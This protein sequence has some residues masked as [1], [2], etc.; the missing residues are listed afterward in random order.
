MTSID[1]KPPDFKI[2]TVPERL[3]AV[4]SV[5]PGIISFLGY[6]V[7]HRR[8]RHTADAVSP[9]NTAIAAPGTD[10]ITVDAIFPSFSAWIDAISAA[11]P[12]A[13]VV[14]TTQPLFCS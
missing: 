13:A 7:P 6:S 8:P 14:S 1:P 10:F 5:R 11:L 4:Q 2:I 3:P 12:G 9:P